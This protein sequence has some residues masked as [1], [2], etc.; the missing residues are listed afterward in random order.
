MSANRTVQ[1]KNGVINRKFQAEFALRILALIAIAVLATL[2]LFFY[3][4][5]ETQTIGYSGTD[6][7]LLPTTEYF[8]PLLLL[9]AIGVIFI[10][11]LIGAVVL[12]RISRRI[13]GPIFRI[14]TLL[15]GMS[16]GDLTHRF[17]FRKNDPLIGLLNR[18]N[19]LAQTMDGKVGMIKAQAADLSRLAE[20]LKT[21][22]ASHPSFQKELERPLRKITT[23]L[24]E[25]QDAANHFKTSQGE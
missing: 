16:Q 15:I 3:A 23:R 14:E 5:R 8:L 6:L 25:L 2:G 13:T 17:I 19:D 7:R 18:I 11:G 10:T 12:I 20:E 21:L 4:A 24:S 9:F 1:R 22:S